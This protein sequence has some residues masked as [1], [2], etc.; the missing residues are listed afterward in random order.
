[1]GDIGRTLRWVRER[2]V[3]DYKFWAA[4]L[5]NSSNLLQDMARGPQD[6]KGYLGPVLEQRLTAGHLAANN[7]LEMITAI[8]ICLQENTELEDLP[9]VH[10]VFNHYSPITK[11]L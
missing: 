8:D 1:M 2:L 7:N 10:T 5:R 6:R 9:A 3:R 4:E 11:I